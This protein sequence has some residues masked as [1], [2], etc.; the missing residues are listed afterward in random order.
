MRNNISFKTRVKESAIDNAIVFNT[1]YIN[2]EYALF[3]EIIKDNPFIIKAI[4][5]NYLHLVGVN[6]SLSA[7][8]FFRKCLN[9]TLI[10]EDF[11][12]SKRGVGTNDL[13]GT[14]RDKIRVLPNMVNLFDGK[15]ILLQ[16]DFKK[17]HIQCAIGSS[18]GCCTLG[19]TNSGHPQSLLRGNRLDNEKSEPVDIILRKETGTDFFTKII[20]CDKKKTNYY[21]NSLSEIASEEIFEK[22]KK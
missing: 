19:F 9:G 11:N 16:S 17:N 12:F 4:K 5:G 21:V 7:D 6:T 8:V 22:L 10:E 15:E 3:S 1:N 20:Y 14:V 13:K 2:Y 18:D